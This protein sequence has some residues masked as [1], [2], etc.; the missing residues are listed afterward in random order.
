MK[1]F[2]IAL[3]VAPILL[4]ICASAQ[5]TPEMSFVIRDFGPR[6]FDYAYGPNWKTGGNIKPQGDG[7]AIETN[8]AGGAGM[9]LNGV[10]LSPQGQTHLVVR[11]KLLEGNTAGKIQINLNGPGADKNVQLDLSKFNKEAYSEVTIPLPAEGKFDKVAQI[12]FQGTN[13]GG[14][15]DVRLLIDKIGTT[16]LDPTANAAALEKAKEAAKTD[17]KAG[18]PANAKPSVAGWGFYP[19]YPDAWMNFLNSQL[20]RTKQGREK[21]DINVVFVGDSITQGWNS[22]IWNEK[23]KPLGAVNYGIGG[24]S[25]RQVLYRL[26]KGI[27]DGISPKAVVLLIG[28][29]NLYGDFNAGNESEIADGIKAV[30]AKIQDKSPNS[31]ILLLGLLPRQNDWFTGRVVKINSQIAKLDDGKKVRYLDLGDKFAATLGKGDVFAELYSGDK[32]H[33]AKK[34]YEVMDAVIYPILQEMLK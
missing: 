20:D 22:D 12:Q 7:V 23:Y 32:L 11:G 19:Q 1:N 16:I 18:P 13:W 8:E 29:N 14:G 15:G 3:M 34:G 26:D 5:S 30:V 6:S 31:K 2:I 24:D 27:L 17:P 25:T 28:T 4:P 21:K 33:L 10:N 9:V